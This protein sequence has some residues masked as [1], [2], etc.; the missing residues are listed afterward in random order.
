MGEYEDVLEEIREGT[1][2]GED[3]AERLEKFKA[4]SL[5]KKAE[6]R[7]EFEKRATEAE[8]KVEALESVPK[9]Q[10]AFEKAGIDFEAL[11]PAEKAL[12]EQYDGEITDEA[13]AELVEANELPL[14]E[15]DPADAEPD[16]DAERIAGTAKRAG[17]NGGRSPQLTP[18]DIGDWTADRWVKFADA[19]PDA[20]EAL[21]Q[22]KTVTGVTG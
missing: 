9:R 20:A 10:A 12:I 6:E 3:A 22:G 13:I 1:I 18:G 7:D 4:T 2:S 15:E 21:R 11:R 5:R 8:A 19:N 14:V 17:A 16:T